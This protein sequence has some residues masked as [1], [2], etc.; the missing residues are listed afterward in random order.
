MFRERDNKKQHHREDDCR[1]F[2][3][4]KSTLKEREDTQMSFLTE[5][6]INKWIIHGN[7]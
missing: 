2:D 6:V 5:S 7:R 4:E 3:K 1:V